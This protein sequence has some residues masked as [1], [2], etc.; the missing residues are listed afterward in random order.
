MVRPTE[1]SPWKV[2]PA[3]SPA[4]GVAVAAPP[5]SIAAYRVGALA[6][7]PPSTSYASICS[8]TTPAVAPRA[9]AVR[10]SA[11]TAAEIGRRKTTSAEPSTRP[12][13]PS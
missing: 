10:A 7:S 6:S 12:P 1:A 8:T 3:K 4:V 5:K 11:A 13:S 9:A 2:T